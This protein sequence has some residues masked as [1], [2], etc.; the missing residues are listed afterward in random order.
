[1]G[2]LYSEVREST[3]RGEP[4]KGIRRTEPVT[5]GRR[6][7]TANASSL[8][9]PCAKTWRGHPDVEQE[10]RFWRKPKGQ[11]H[12]TFRVY[13]CQNIHKYTHVPVKHYCLSNLLSIPTNREC[14][15]RAIPARAHLAVTL[16]QCCRVGY[17]FPK[18]GGVM[19]A[20]I[21]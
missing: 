11:R 13:A 16:L 10:P 4:L 12:H 15:S 7:L 18:K 2:S 20:C 19:G 8:H 17:V 21:F 3:A 1:M 9:G 14:A 6:R 5:R